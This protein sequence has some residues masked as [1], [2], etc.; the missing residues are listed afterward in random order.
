[1]A[2]PKL[3]PTGIPLVDEAVS[4]LVVEL[5]QQMPGHTHSLYLFGSFV[6]GSASAASDVDLFVVLNGELAD[7]DTAVVRAMSQRLSSRAVRHIDLLPVTVDQLRHDGHWRLEANSRLVAGVDLRPEMPSEPLDAYLRRYTHAPYAYMA[8]E[9]RHVDRLVFPLSAPDPN[10]V[11]RGY[12][13][14]VDGESHATTKVFVATVCW[15]ASLLVGFQAGGKVASRHASV[16]VYRDAVGGP[17][18][19]FVDEVY[20]HC[21]LDWDYRVPESEADRQQLQRLTG[22]M[23]DFENHYLA[24]YRRFLLDQMASPDQD[25]RLEAI[26]RLRDWIVFPDDEVRQSLSAINLG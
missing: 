25:A 2:Q 19:D 22:N 4:R 23:P 12:T 21:T 16:Q 11:F 14:V 26:E 18:A 3:I 13:E 17:W 5:N 15:I 9:L 7:A 8:Q 1:M 24:A 20:R 10:A 6:D